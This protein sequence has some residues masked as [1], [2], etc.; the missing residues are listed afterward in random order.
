MPKH[1][2]SLSFLTA[3]DAV[4]LA[5][6]ESVFLNLFGNPAFPTPPIMQGALD[7]L[8]NDLDAA[9]GAMEQGGTAATSAKNDKRKLLND[10]LEKLAHYVEEVS[11]NN[12][13]TIL[14]SG[15]EVA[16]NN[17]A[18]SKLDTP[19]INKLI[20]G[21]AGELIVGIPAIPNAKVYEVQ[22]ALVGAGGVVGPWQSAP[23]FTNSRAM[24][25][26]GLT[27]GE[28]YMLRVRAVGG[29]TGYSEW[30]NPVSHMCM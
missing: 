16:S 19:E 10:G 22:Y 15:F 5:R 30:S 29:S 28:D 26:P 6:A 24:H 20:N 9:M 25:V 8:R 4:A 14:S 13:T 12:L 23:L 21:G 1:H 2:V 3:S 18:Q 17:K 27:R 11:G 7:T